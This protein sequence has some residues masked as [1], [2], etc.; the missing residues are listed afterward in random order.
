MRV[1]QINQITGSSG[2]EIIPL[3]Y[4]MAEL[5]LV[6]VPESLRHMGVTIMCGPFFS[7]MPFPPRGLHT[8]SHVRYTPHYHW[9]D[10]ER[11]IDKPRFGFDRESERTAFPHMI[12]DARKYLPILADCEY[13][14]SLWEVKTILP[15]N[16][17]DDGRPILYKP[18]HGI[19]NHHV[20]MGGKI[21]NVYD[22]VREIDRSLS[23]SGSADGRE[24]LQSSLHE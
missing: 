3:K 24:M 21:D 23:T 10:G 20:V 6:R 7:C 12:R 1:S 14:D 19:P 2:L 8:L 9:F 18:H 13:V 16:E 22:A 4:E 17:I 5:C 11:D 15:R